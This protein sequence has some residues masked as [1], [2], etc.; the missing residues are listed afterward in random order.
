MRVCKKSEE[1]QAI[2][3]NGKVA[4]G[5]QTPA[6]P[7]PSVADVVMFRRSSDDTV[8]ARD[9]HFMQVNGHKRQKLNG[10]TA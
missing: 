6:G 5:M 3:S 8:G 4:H 7:Q 1:A 9:M 10:L 2:K